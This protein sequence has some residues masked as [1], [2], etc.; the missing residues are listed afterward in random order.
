MREFLEE[1]RIN[2]DEV[3]RHIMN[4]SQFHRIQGSKEI[5]DAAEYI[6]GELKK[7]GIDPSSL[8][9]YAG[10]KADLGIDSVV[11]MVEKAGL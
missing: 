9:N 3:L 5:V 6:L 7:A 8:V 4:I 10:F 11:S 1:A 2:V